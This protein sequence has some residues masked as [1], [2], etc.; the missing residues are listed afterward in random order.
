MEKPAGLLYKENIT[1]TRPVSHNWFEFIVDSARRT[2]SV[3]G[4]MGSS[5]PGTLV[6]LSL[7]KPT[8]F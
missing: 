5:R 8:L 4:T 1:L 3:I 6:S 2:N 7:Q